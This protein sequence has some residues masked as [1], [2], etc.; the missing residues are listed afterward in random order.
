MIRIGREFASEFD[1]EPSSKYKAI[2]CVA[3]RGYRVISVAAAEAFV[4]SPLAIEFLRRASV[5]EPNRDIVSILGAEA[6]IFGMALAAKKAADVLRESRRP[7]FVGMY[8]VGR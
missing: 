1:D 8:I 5:L 3:E 2:A 7:G 6:V 4:F